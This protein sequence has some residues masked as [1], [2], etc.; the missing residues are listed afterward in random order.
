MGTLTESQLRALRFIR[1]F[2][3]TKSEWRRGGKLA[4]GPSEKWTDM[5]LSGPDGSINITADDQKAIL[6]F[7]DGSVGASL[8]TLN[9]S[10][11]LALQQAER[12]ELYA[13]RSM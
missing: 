8:Y 9:S 12:A 7:F 6:S 13:D 4:F 1:D 3:I 5:R 10:G 11:V 2:R